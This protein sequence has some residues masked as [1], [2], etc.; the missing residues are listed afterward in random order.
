[1]EHEL[2]KQ[3]EQPYEKFQQYGPEAL[4]EVEL[5]AIIIRTGT[6]GCDATSL[7]R[8]VLEL[9]QGDNGLLGLYHITDAQLKSIKGIGEVKAIKIKAILELSKRIATSTARRQLQVTNPKLLADYFMERM[10]HLEQEVVY[11]VMLDSKNRII[12]EHLLSSGTVNTSLLSTREVFKM[13]LAYQA[14]SIILLHNHPSGDPAPSKQ[15]IGIT[16]TVAEIGL[17]LEIPLLDH[18]I[19][20]DNCYSSFKE[21]HLI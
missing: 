12:A 5:L 8:K 6:S 18:V 9:G 1:M 10:R 3:S 2:H 15:D 16:R 4:T 17:L 20:G 7:A 19:I 11:V 13:A 21:Q 14:V